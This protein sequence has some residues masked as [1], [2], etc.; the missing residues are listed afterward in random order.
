MKFDPDPKHIIFGMTRDLYSSY[1]ITNVFFCLIGRLIIIM[2]W[3]V[4]FLVWKW[5]MMKKWNSD[6]VFDQI[7]CFFLFK[8]LIYDGVFDEIQQK[9]M[10]FTCF[11]LSI[12]RCCLFDKLY[13]FFFNSFNVEKFLSS[14][15]SS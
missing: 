13:T 8:Y 6:N 1:T 4:W 9:N 15:F 11:S 7:F 10:H 2:N 3:L 14:F 12:S 5:M